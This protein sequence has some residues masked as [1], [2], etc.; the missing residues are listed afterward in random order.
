MGNLAVDA[1]LTEVGPNTFERMLAPAWEIWGPNGGYMAALALE[2][3][4]LTS[5]RSR[6]ANATV[7]FLG[8]ASFD[9]PVTVAASTQRATRQATSVGIRVEQDGKPILAAM[10]WALDDGLDGLMHDD[11]AFPDVPTWSE[12]PTL[13]ERI[14]ADPGAEPSRYHF[15]DNFEQRPA[16]WLDSREWQA[17]ELGPALYQNWLRFTG[18]GATDDPWAQAAR[19]LLLVD[20]GAWPSIGRRHRTEEWMAPTI[21]VSCEFHRLTT[22][23]E[24]FLL[25]G[26]SPFAGEGLVASHQHVWN[27][28]GELLAS[29]ISH[30]L[31]RRI[32]RSTRVP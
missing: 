9:T 32:P 5:G 3:A 28:R 17:R 10:I 20:L 26:E 12:L 14:A 30:L 4:R 31:C 1:A 25:Q 24:W 8:A 19:L 29:G 11:G 27:D 7:H 16:S 18:G 13:D 23:D 15:W 21:D 6:P 22:G 2:A